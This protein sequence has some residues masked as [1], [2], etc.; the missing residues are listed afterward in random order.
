MKEER[1]TWQKFT[2]CTHSYRPSRIHR[3][4]KVIVSPNLTCSARIRINILVGQHLVFSY[5][6]KQ[7]EIAKSE[8]AVVALL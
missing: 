5:S 4:N 2:A 6:S 8:A 1:I 7:I 3:R